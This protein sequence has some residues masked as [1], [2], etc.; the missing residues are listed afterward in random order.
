M[1][2]TTAI[3][4]S[5]C[6]IRGTVSRSISTTRKKTMEYIFSLWGRRIWLETRKSD[7]EKLVLSYD[8]KQGHEI[9]A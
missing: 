2:T 6:G 1:A 8:A 9:H 7:D 5:T 4:N 3:A